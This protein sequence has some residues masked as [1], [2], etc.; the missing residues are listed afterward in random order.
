MTSSAFPSRVETQNNGRGAIRTC[1]DHFST[2]IDVNT[3]VTVVEDR[4]DL[5]HPKWLLQS[6]ATH[7]KHFL[8]E[9]ID[10]DR[11]SSVAISCECYGG[12]DAEEKVRPLI[13][14]E[15]SLQFLFGDSIFSAKVLN[16]PIGFPGLLVL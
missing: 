10:T 11:G 8:P 3:T 13:L 1:C 4:S 15:G 7:W 6:K 9:F 16:L 2:G 12:R 5:N 14:L